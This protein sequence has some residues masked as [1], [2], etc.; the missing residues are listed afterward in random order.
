MYRK[1]ALALSLFNQGDLINSAPA[2]RILAHALVP[3]SFLPL[4]HVQSTWRGW[5]TTD[6]Q[7]RGADPTAEAAASP[8]RLG[9][10][11]RCGTLA[12]GFLPWG[13]IRR[14]LGY[15][16]LY[17]GQMVAELG[18]VTSSLWFPFSLYFPSFLHGMSKVKAIKC[19][20]HQSSWKNAGMKLE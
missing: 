6:L 16:T 9:R 19:T 13:K 2:E 1:T 17:R 4:G 18:A 3:F 10:P 20:S 12:Q 5:A 11:G 8:W 7:N 15:P 14:P